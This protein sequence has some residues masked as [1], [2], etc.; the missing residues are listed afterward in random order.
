MLLDWGRPVHA[1]AIGALVLA[2]LVLARRFIAA[3]VERAI[4]FSGLGVTLF[5]IGMLVSAFALRGLA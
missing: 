5:V 3:P 4:W 1:A 2:Q